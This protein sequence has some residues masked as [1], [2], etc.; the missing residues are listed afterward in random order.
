MLLPALAGLLL[1]VADAPPARPAVA[2]RPV[3]KAG[4]S[5]AEADALTRK[6][7]AIEER[8]RAQKARKSP[9]VQVSQAEVNSYLNLAYASELPKGVSD[10]E[11]TFGRDR[12]E[13][14]G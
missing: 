4:L 3:P 9:A 8:H 2:A 6:L 10:I 14:K 11:V 12:I 7:A 5:W 1:L 13:A